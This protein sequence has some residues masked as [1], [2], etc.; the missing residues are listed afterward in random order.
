MLQN[1]FKK[2]SKRAGYAD[3]SSKR[4]LTTS[5]PDGKINKN[6]RNA[7]SEKLCGRKDYF[8]L[9]IER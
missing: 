7:I 4:I 6:V 8:R 2:E 1:C 3:M 5:F 9:R